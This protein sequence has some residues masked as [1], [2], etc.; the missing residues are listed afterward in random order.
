MRVASSR[1]YLPSLV[2][3]LVLAAAPC[4]AE[5]LAVTGGE[6]ARSEPIAL[7][8]LGEISGGQGVHV[9]LLSNQQLTATSSGNSVTANSIQSGDVSFT[10]GALQ[11]FNGIGNFVVNTG[12]NNT[13][14][15]SIS[16]SIATAP[17]P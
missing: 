17:A 5:E 10:S 12:A 14:Q 3:A 16:V 2:A 7:E 9:E 15:G 8:D 6:L 4:A 1:S 11:G 13:L